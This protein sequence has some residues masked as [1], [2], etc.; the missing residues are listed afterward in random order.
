MNRKKLMGDQDQ[1]NENLYAYLEGFSPPLRDILER[2]KRPKAC[3]A[4]L[5]PAFAP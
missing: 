4:L 5:V 1:I 3:K 2:N